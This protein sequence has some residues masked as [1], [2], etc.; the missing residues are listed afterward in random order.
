MRE[1]LV[2]VVVPIYNTEKYVER[3]V[4]S[5]C[6]QLYKNIEILLINDG[7]PDN[8]ESVC[9]KL[10]NKDQRIHYYYQ[11]NKGVAAARNLG[12]KN[13]NGK[14]ILFCDSD[15]EWDTQLLKSVVPIMEEND[16]IDMV[17][18]GFVSK[19][20]K[21]F[22]D[23]QLAEGEYTQKD[24]LIEYF[25]DNRIYRN[26]S[27]CCVGIYR[28]DLIGKQDLRFDERLKHGE[29]G[30]FV[31]QYAQ[32]CRKIQVVEQYLY[33]Y[34]PY[35]ED[36]VSAT[37]RNLKELYN[38][39]ELCCIL[40]EKFYRKWDN[41]L[42]SEE[43]TRAYGAFYDRLIGRLVRFAA[44]S[45]SQT[46]AK[47]KDQ[48]NKLLCTDYVEVAGHYYRPKRKS[49]SRVIPVCMRHRW[50][51]LLWFVLRSHRQKYYQMYGKKR[52]V[53]SIW[54]SDPVLA[55]EEG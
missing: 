7:S 19:D 34:Y 22:A 24:L 48:L 1:P 53:E 14:Y 40:F 37:A 21:F 18:Y 11:D 16:S 55:F 9:K 12:I 29:D 13:A 54:K 23:D 41:E 45:T 42:S 27:S 32:C 33:I 35:F 17:R 36:R 44:Y 28:T 2:S 8:A 50:A 10:V 5:I 15:D 26:M 51:G 47:D 3:A 31:I 20:Q 52:Y 46:R 6:N 30:K 25:S 4:S 39:Y 38:E 49:D 43:K